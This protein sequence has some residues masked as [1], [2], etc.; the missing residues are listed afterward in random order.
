MS[1]DDSIM[2]EE[3]SDAFATVDDDDNDEDDDGYISDEAG[4]Y[5]LDEEDMD[6]LGYEDP[7]YV[8]GV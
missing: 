6:G 7:G 2:D 3:L 8:V 4:D 1:F 5:A